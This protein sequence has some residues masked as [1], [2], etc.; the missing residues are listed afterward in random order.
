MYKKHTRIFD[1]PRQPVKKGV[2]DKLGKKEADGEL[3]DAL[4]KSVINKKICQLL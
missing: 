4:E 1:D 3:N 2:T